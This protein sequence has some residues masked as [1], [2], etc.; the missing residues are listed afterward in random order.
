M[1][2]ELDPV[3]FRIHR[4]SCYLGAGLRP[5]PIA[6]SRTWSDGYVR[7]EHGR[8]ESRKYVSDERRIGDLGQPG[9]LADADAD[10]PLRSLEHHVHGSGILDRHTAVGPSRR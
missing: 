3:V 8:H 10:D 4:R 9:I 6:R 2:G 5:G 7:D 1:E